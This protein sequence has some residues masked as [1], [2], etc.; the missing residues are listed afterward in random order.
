MTGSLS[1][2]LLRLT[3]ELTVLA[4]MGLLAPRLQASCGDYVQVGQSAHAKAEI[5]VGKFHPDSMLPISAEIPVNNRPCSGP[6]CGRQPSELP[7]PVA[8]ASTSTQCDQWALPVAQ[9]QNLS[10]DNEFPCADAQPRAPAAHLFRIERPP[11]L[12]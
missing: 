5:S 7:V 3:I 11:R 8:P 1:T 6:H 4:G 10:A 2:K 9:L 12:D